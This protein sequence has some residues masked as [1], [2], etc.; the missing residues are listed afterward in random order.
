MTW[1]T[2]QILWPDIETTVP[3]LLREAFAA[4]SMDVMCGRNI[5][6]PRPSKM[7]IVNRDGGGS[8][9]LL[10]FPTIRVRVFAPT[11]DEAN[12]LARLASALVFGLKGRGGITNVS[13]QSGPYDV[14]DQSDAHLRYLLFDLTVKGT[15]LDVPVSGS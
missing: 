4:R 3:T 11:W 2:S 15:P 9:G 7:V 6:D 13:K 12:D 8:D 5:P 10:D 1:Q 14:P